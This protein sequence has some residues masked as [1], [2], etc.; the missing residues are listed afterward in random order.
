MNNGRIIFL[1]SLFSIAA[2]LPWVVPIGDRAAVPVL[3]L[4]C[5]SI[6]SLAWLLVA[7][8]RAKRRRV[9]REVDGIEIPLAS[10]FIGVRGIPLLALGSN[11]LATYLR[12]GTTHVVHG[13]FFNR[14]PY[15]WIE[16][17]EA[18]TLPATRALIFVWR[19]SPQTFVANVA[20]D[21]ARLQALRW[22]EERG[23]PLAES[24]RQLLERSND[25]AAEPRNAIRAR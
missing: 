7:V 12:L 19:S 3:S 2:T 23:V 16:R 10:S 17:V 15:G 13:M 21:A 22:L 25:D 9:E 4:A 20:T 11:S 24:A 5:G 8:R 14:S 18:M 1:A 6:A